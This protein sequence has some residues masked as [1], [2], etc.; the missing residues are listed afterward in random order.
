LNKKLFN[1]LKY[2]VMLGV[3]VFLFWL[4]YRNTFSD[5]EEMAKLKKA[6]LHIHY[7]YILAAFV[8]MLL[9]NWSRAVRWNLLIQPL[10]YKTSDRNGF[11]AV[12][13]GYFAN[14]AFPRLGEVS[15]CVVLNRTNNV[16]VD[17]LVGTVIVERIFD[18]ICLFIIVGLTLIL[19]F[20]KIR[21]FF[22]ENITKKLGQGGFMA[23]LTVFNI[24]IAITVIIIGIALTFAL[25]R[26]YRNHKAVAKVTTLAKGLFDGMKGVGKMKKKWLF[27]FHSAFIWAMYY[28][29]VYLCFLALSSTEHL[30]LVA[31]LTVL[32]T[33]S[34]GF[35]M[36]VQGGIGAYHFAVASTLV[37]YGLTEKEGAVF[38][39]VAHTFQMSVF[40]LVGGLSLIYVGYRYRKAPKNEP[41]PANQE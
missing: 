9:S 41:A 28:L 12:M 5:P 19:E 36:P 25:Y 11:L 31:A 2:V 18:F 15:R 22:V 26:R 16:P 34:F 40:V 33:G 37:L 38:A 14:L 30:G 8:I 3:G 6:I 35:V 21:N 24:T 1:A 39:L 32:V 20:E 13:V 7:G 23:L 4:V 29:M 17:K 27:L 10:G